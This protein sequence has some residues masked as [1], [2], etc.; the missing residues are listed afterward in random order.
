VSARSNFNLSLFASINVSACLKVTSNSLSFWVNSCSWARSFPFGGMLISRPSFHSAS[1][2]LDS[3]LARSFEPLIVQRDFRREKTI[4]PG[5]LER[6][7]CRDVNNLNYALKPILFNY[8]LVQ[9]L[10]NN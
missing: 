9:R 5:Q 2:F 10:V 6:R 4:N 3:D 1:Y 7:L 8:M